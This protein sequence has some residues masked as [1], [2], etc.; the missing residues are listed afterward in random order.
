MG[1]PRMRP[2]KPEILNSADFL[3]LSSVGKLIFMSLILLSDDEGRQATDVSRLKSA[4]CQDASA[5]HIRDQLAI[6]ERRGMIQR[7]EVGAAYLQLRNW[8]RHQKPQWPRPSS[9]PAPPPADGQ[10]TLFDP[11]SFLRTS[12]E[13][14]HTSIDRDWDRGPGLETKN[15]N[16]TSRHGVWTTARARACSALVQLFEKLESVVVDDDATQTHDQV[17]RVTQDLGWVTSREVPS[18]Y[19]DHDGRVDL[20]TQSPLG[21]IGI[22]IDDVTP[23]YKSFEKLRN[24]DVA[25]RVLALRNAGGIFEPPDGIDAIV[26]LRCRVKPQPSVLGE[27]QVFEAW[28]ASLPAGVDRR[29]TDGRRK[30]IRARLAAGYSVE[31]LCDAVSRGW[32]VDAERWPERASQNDL[33]ILLRSDEQA[34]KFIALARNGH[35]P[36][37]LFKPDGSVA[38]LHGRLQA[39]DAMAIPR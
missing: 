12:H 21:S 3:A 10:P 11:E 4:V 19:G 26:G 37:P 14:S 23:R 27:D 1:R 38:R 35:A 20:V 32:Q 7:Y 18:P 22:E 34:E 39:I 13:L 8:A 15:G 36:V 29:F 25:Y 5:A 33:T 30:K 16:S 31:D 17:E 24:L 28:T 6:M 9:Y 2:I